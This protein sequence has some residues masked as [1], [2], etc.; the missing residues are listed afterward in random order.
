MAYVLAGLAGFVAFLVVG[1]GVFF[2]FSVL[3]YKR[4]PKPM[5]ATVL[6]IGWSLVLLVPVWVARSVHAH[7]SR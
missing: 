3:G 7:L 1:I 6:L 4:M 5:E 2:A